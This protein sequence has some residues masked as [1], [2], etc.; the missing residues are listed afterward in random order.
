MPLAACTLQ[1]DAEAS[2]SRDDFRAASPSPANVALASPRGGVAVSA[3][4]QD[5]RGGQPSP[6]GVSS[7]ASQHELRER[8][9]ANQAVGGMPAPL[10]RQGSG[11]ALV[12][13]AAAEAGAEPGMVQIKRGTLSI[14]VPADQFSRSVVPISPRSGNASPRGSAP[15]SGATSPTDAHGGVS[16]SI[17]SGDVANPGGSRSVRSVRPSSINSSDPQ[18]AAL[19]MEIR[20]WRKQFKNTFGYYP[21]VRDLN[22]VRRVLPPVAH[23]L[24]ALTQGHCGGAAAGQAQ[25]GNEEEA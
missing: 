19:E 17:S 7:S 14:A 12:G 21:G 20:E 1:T 11:P 8:A 9:F 6:R 2:G 4:V 23:V 15:P 3:S 22:D 10:R 5:F 18:L 16:P 24:R 25:E 13:T